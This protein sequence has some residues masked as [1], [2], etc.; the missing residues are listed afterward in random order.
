[1]GQLIDLTG[2]TYG[3]WTVLNRAM[4][5]PAGVTMWLCRCKC[6]VVKPVS[7]CTLRNGR[8]QGCLQCR[9]MKHGK[10]RT[11]KYRLWVQ[12][13]SRAKKAGV[14][15][16]LELED[17]RIPARCPLLGLRLRF[18]SKRCCATN[19]S[20]D[21]ID[22][23]KGYTKGNVWVISWRA[24]VIKHDATLEELEAITAAVRERLVR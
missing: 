24:N 1:M 18:S 6:G 21:R 2:Q 20:L 15:F 10:A 23:T 13:K 8:S 7:G 19:P 12:A 14:A 11:R 17:V 4:S 5:T 9:P 22:P 16:N 3:K